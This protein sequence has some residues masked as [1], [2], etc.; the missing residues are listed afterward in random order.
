MTTFLIGGGWS[1]QARDA[2]YGPFLRAAGEDPTV[3]CVVLDEGDGDE[4]FQR[5]ASALSGTAPCR[6][7]PVLVPEGGTLDVGRLADADA[8]LVCGGLTPAYASALAPRADDVSTWLAARDRPYAG[9]SAGASVAAGAAVVGG[10]LSGGVPV[11]PEDAA[12]DRDEVAVVPGVGLVP[13]AVDVHA[14]QWGTLPRLIDAVRSGQADQGIAIDENTL[15]VVE[16]G[17]VG[18]RG[19]GVWGLGRAHRVRRSR[20]GVEVVSAGDGGTLAV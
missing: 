2:V 7:V 17:R 13:F 18:V 5:W 6:P 19:V 8:L 9:F 12:E 11:C 4:Q 16:D 15:V 3:A 10:W 14:A 20:D 1:P